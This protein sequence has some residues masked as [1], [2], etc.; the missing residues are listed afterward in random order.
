MG[1]PEGTTATGNI[2]MLD[3]WPLSADEI[4]MAGVHSREFLVWKTGV[5]G[6]DRANVGSPILG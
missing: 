4:R 2:G 5:F 3:D 1:H 6:M